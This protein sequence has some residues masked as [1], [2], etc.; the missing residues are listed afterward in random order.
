M[1]LGISIFTLTLR[2]ATSRLVFL[3]PDMSVMSAHVPRVYS[4]AYPVIFYRSENFDLARD[5][6]H[7]LQPFRLTLGVYTN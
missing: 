5:R 6:L 3:L 4:K 7:L 1:G 2:G